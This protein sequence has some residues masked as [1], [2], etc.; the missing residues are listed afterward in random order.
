MKLRLECFDGERDGAIAAIRSSFKVKSV[1]KA[2]PNV[3]QT[4]TEGTPCESR[5]Y[6]ETT[7]TAPSVMDLIVKDMFRFL[8]DVSAMYVIDTEPEIERM[9]AFYAA[10][11]AM[12]DDKK[13][14]L[15]AEW[16]SAL[17][18]RCVKGGLRH[19]PGNR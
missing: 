3:R 17:L 5:Y 2:Y 10:G 12:P 14:E 8:A 19:A 11:G 9:R 15:L 13:F 7:G 4:G 6:I 18:G 16:R 1:S